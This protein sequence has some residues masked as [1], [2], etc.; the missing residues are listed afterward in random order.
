MRNVGP[1]VC[2]YVD[3]G[4]SDYPE[5]APTGLRAVWPRVPVRRV[6]EAMLCKSL[7]GHCRGPATFACVRFCVE[8]ALVRA[9][10]PTYR[11]FMDTFPSATQT[12][13]LEERQHIAGVST[14]RARLFST[15][16]DVVL[17][18]TTDIPQHTRADW[19]SGSADPRFN[20][21]NR[22]RI[23]YRFSGFIIYWDVPGTGAGRQ[24]G[25]GPVSHRELARSGV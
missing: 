15:Q 5:E 19:L 8:S 12:W 6:R 21:K 10:S 17:N 23:G 20:S 14:R 9:A 13:L 24:P 7:V 3:R 18:T 16:R 11:Y 22:N 25:I 1:G 4:D 2:C